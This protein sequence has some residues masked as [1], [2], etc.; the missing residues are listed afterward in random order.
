VTDAALTVGVTG[1]T[2]TV[3]RGLLP[4]LEA[5]PSIRSVLGIASRPHTDAAAEYSKLEY[6]RA[7]VRDPAALARALDGAD[8]VVHLAFSIYGFRQRGDT[9]DDVNLD[10]S[11]NVLEAANAV[12]ARRFIYTSSAAVYGFG[13]DRPDLVDE[14]SPVE[15]DDEHFYSRHKAELERVLRDRLEE[16][17]DMEWVFFRPC[18]IVG[19]HAAG[20]GSHML[21][22]ILSRAAGALATVGAAAG[23]RPYVPGPPVPLQ[24]VHERDVGQAVHRAISTRET[25]RIYNLGGEGMVAARD[26]PRHI[27][28]R[29]LPIPGF[30]SRALIAAAGRL[31][32][33]TPGLSWSTLLSRPLQ[34]DTTRARGELGWEPR[35]TSAEAL[36]A[37]RRALAI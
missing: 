34:L 6:R 10:G 33:V 9:L 35:F 31:P 13:N 7:D 5:D 25:G 17:P 36:A 37:T 22:G 15:P 19:P 21:P 1:V 2:G 16:L 29:T 3:G 14:D 24:F 18:A 26:V 23:L 27:G 28:L 32:V 8:V 12:G 11:L 30:V 4:Y 20:G